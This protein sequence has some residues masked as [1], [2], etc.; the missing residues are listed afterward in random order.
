[1]VRVLDCRSVDPKFKSLTDLQLDLIQVF[2]GST[3]W[4]HLYTVNWPASCQLGFLTCSF[5]F[6]GPEKPQRGEV[7]QAYIT[8]HIEGYKTE[9][10]WILL[11]DS[12][13]AQ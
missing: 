10:I 5:C 6:I 2:P 8:L 3:P 11:P 1:M 4:L 7:N 13:I 9:I 12:L